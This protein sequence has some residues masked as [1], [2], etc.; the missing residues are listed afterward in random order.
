[1]LLLL[2]ASK[3]IAGDEWSKGDVNR[4]IAWSSF[5]VVDWLQTRYIATHPQDFYETNPLLGKH[6]GLGYVNSVFIGAIIT[7]PLVVDLLPSRYRP[8]L[9]WP[10]LVFEGS[11]VG[12][13]AAIGIRLRF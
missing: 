8:W 1:L 4:Q 3:A 11:L 10:G 9:Q 12:R 2:P 7:A 5:Q 13:N 6:P